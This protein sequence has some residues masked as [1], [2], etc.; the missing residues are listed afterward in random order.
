MPVSH[1]LLNMFKISPACSVTVRMRDTVFA[2]SSR[3]ERVLMGDRCFSRE[4]IQKIL[5]DGSAL[6]LCQ[7]RSHTDGMCYIPQTHWVEKN[8][9]RKSSWVVVNYCFTVGSPGRLLKM[10]SETLTWGPGRP[11]L[12][13]SADDS[14]VNL[15]S[16]TSTLDYFSVIKAVLLFAFSLYLITLLGLLSRCPL[17]YLRLLLLFILLLF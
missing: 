4:G 3:L 8:R 15:G 14:V 16:R 10:K 9:N 12:Q 17:Q 13:S 7:P 6:L 5:P 2:I 1:W 11:F